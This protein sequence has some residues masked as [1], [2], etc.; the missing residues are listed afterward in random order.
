MPDL[1][2]WVMHVRAGLPAPGRAGHC[3][4]TRADGTRCE[5]RMYGEMPLRTRQGVWLDSQCDTCRRPV[6]VI[7]AQHPAVP[8]GAQPV[9]RASLPDWMERAA[10]C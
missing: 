9:E 5:G 10:N 8:S 2:Q 4:A 1:Q 3:T 6:A 7:V